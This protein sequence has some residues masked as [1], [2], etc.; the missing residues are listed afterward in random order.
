MN[1]NIDTKSARNRLAVRVEPY[2]QKLSKGCY[3][4]FRKTA[5][6]S[7]CWLARKWDGSRYEWT[8]LGRLES[9]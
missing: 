9:F 6:S 8:P 5:A 4:G 1:T 3:V 2:W 7:N